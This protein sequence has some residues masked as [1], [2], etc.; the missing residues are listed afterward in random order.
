MIWIGDV[1]QNCLEEINLVPLHEKKNLGWS[2]KE[3]FQDFEE[4]GECYGNND[5][6][7]DELTYPVVVLSLIHI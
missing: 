2:I 1:G 7:E 6:G 5:Q 3:G 4:G